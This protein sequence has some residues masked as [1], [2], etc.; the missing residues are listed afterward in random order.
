[1]SFWLLILQYYNIILIGFREQKLKV[2]CLKLSI[3]VI[4]NYKNS[5]VFRGKVFSISNRR[6]NFRPKAIEVV[7]LNMKYL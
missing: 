6:E 1:M 2:Y 4:R 5:N 7:K 3:H